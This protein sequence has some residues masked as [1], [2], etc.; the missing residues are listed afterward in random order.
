VV[1][2]VISV[3]C[4]A[5]PPFGV[6]YGRSPR[7]SLCVVRRSPAFRGEAKRRGWLTFLFLLCLFVAKQNSP[8]FPQNPLKTPYFFLKIPSF[9]RFFLTF[10]SLFRAFF[11]RHGVASERS[12]D[13]AACLR[14]VFP[15]SGNVAEVVCVAPAP[16]LVESVRF[17]R[18]GPG[19]SFG[20]S[21]GGF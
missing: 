3:I 19:N 20:I 12:A 18:L 15:A 16:F 7:V 17:P 2:S 1:K 4:E 13:P 11:A 14:V 5:L 8:K 21:R 6:P 10:P 9:F